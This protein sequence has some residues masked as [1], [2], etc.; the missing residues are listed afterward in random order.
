MGEKSKNKW[1]KGRT[2]KCESA[3]SKCQKSEM[4]KIRNDKMLNAERE[5]FG[6]VKWTHASKKSSI[7]SIY[8][9]KASYEKRF[10]L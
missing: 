7:C 5:K 4:G 3:S 2:S 8:C 6:N 10:L 1:G 9:A